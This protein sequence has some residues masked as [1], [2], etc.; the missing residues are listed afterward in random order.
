MKKVKFYTL[1]CK[2]N[3]YETQEI[4]ERFLEAGFLEVKG[5]EG[6]DVYVVNTCTVT[7]KADK[8]SLYFIHRS[9]HE[10]PKAKIIV[11][12]CLSEL[13]RKKIKAQPGVSL[14]VSNRDKTQIV[15]KLRGKR[16]KPEQGISFLEG[17]TRA[18]LK[19]QDGCDNFCSYCRVP[20]ARGKSRS[21]P[22]DEIIIEAERL[23]RNGFKEIVLTGICLGSYGGDHKPRK[24]LGDVIEKLEKIEGILR[25][26]LS[27][28]EAGDVSDRLIAKMA[29]STKLCPHLHIPIQ[30]GDDEI[31]K[32]MRRK[33]SRWDYLDLVKKIR[34]KVRQV[35][36]TTDVLVGFPGEEEKNFFNTMDLVRKITPLRCH[37]FPFSPR[38]G[39]AAANF[40][41]IPQKSVVKERVKRLR[42]IAQSCSRTFCQKSLGKKMAVLIE[43]RSPDNPG[44]WEGHTDTYIKVLINSRKNLRN[45]LVL[46]RLKKVTPGGVLSEI[47]TQKPSLF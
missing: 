14:V 37:I 25:I 39:T 21:K 11:T 18:F 13:E 31:L 35:A 20:L 45:K 28:I 44:F 27:S 12:G 3:Q 41:G 8:D 46:A 19:I 7:A 43:G 23:V 2:V 6:A 30:S 24:D 29:S 36:I 34:K 9:Y 15:F 4:R 38:P 40:P 5:K 26:R 22:I 10:N 16:K 33:Y 1:G 17:H 32:K 47:L 42:I